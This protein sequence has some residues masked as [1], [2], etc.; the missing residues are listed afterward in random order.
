LEAAEIPP[1]YP[2]ARSSTAV[3][4]GPVDIADKRCWLPLRA[5]N[6]L[7]TSTSR[8]LPEH[9]KLRKSRNVIEFHD[10]RRFG[11]DVKIQ[12]LPPK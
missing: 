10:Y 6:R 4:Y 5:E 11:A 3:E 7:A 2:I 1:D 8:D 9:E 12:Y